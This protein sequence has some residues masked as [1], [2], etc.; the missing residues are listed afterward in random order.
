MN[1]CSLYVVVRQLPSPPHHH[2][3]TE[4]ERGRRE[5]YTERCKCNFFKIYIK[6]YNTHTYGS[7]SARVAALNIQ[8]CPRL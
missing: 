5:T 7:V 1:H 8:L 2:C 3:S 6:Y 4:E